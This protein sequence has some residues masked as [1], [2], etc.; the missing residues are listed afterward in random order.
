MHRYSK[1]TVTLPDLPIFVYRSLRLES[2]M[3]L[4][5][6]IVPKFGVT[7]LPIFV[8]TLPDYREIGSKKSADSTNSG[9]G[10]TAYTTT[11]YMY[12]R[13]KYNKY[14]LLL[15]EKKLNFFISM[16]ALA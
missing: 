11:I 14:I 12:I 1:S 15:S 8:F 5:I 9:S 6:C 10:T 4:P 2:D 13:T 16:L 7:D 3:F